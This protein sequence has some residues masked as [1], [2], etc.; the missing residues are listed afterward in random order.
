MLGFS[1]KVIYATVSAETLISSIKLN[2]CKTEWMRF[3]LHFGKKKNQRAV[4][5]TLNVLSAG[6]DLLK[7][8]YLYNSAVKP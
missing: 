7:L 4:I 3:F 2:Q 8:A 1:F 6:V 5:T